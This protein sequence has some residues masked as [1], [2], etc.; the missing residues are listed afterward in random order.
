[1]MQFLGSIGSKSKLLQGSLVS[2]SML[3][4]GCLVSGSRCFATTTASARWLHSTHMLS[5][6]FKGYIRFTFN[7]IRRGY[8]CMRVRG[9]P[10]VL[11]QE[12]LFDLHGVQAVGGCCRRLQSYSIELD[13]HHFLHTARRGGGCMRHANGGGCEAPGDSDLQ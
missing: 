13:S 7:K 5:F 2:G 4:M 9:G 12:M 1:M 11:L 3:V 8:R 10:D 6:G